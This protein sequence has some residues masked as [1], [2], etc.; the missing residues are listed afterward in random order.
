[1]NVRELKVSTINYVPV[2]PLLAKRGL[3]DSLSGRWGG[4]GWGGLQSVKFIADLEISQKWLY[5]VSH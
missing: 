2:C 4:G 1:M 5:F 3:I